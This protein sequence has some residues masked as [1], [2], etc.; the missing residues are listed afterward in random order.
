MELFSLQKI[1][2]CALYHDTPL[3]R[4]MSCGGRVRQSEPEVVTNRFAALSEAAVDLL[5]ISRQGYHLNLG[6]ESSSSIGI[7]EL[8][9]GDFTKTNRLEP[10]RFQSAMRSLF[11]FCVCLL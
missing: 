4:E 10:E 3:V 2:M 5:K 9:L 1:T 7:V 6:F 8:V 11:N